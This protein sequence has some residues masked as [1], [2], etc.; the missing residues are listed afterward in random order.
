MDAL[1]DSTLVLYNKI[2]ENKDDTKLQEKI[3]KYKNN[4]SIQLTETTYMINIIRDSNK[5]IL[6]TITN[7]YNSIKSYLDKNI[8]SLKNIINDFDEITL[9]TNNDIIIDN[10]ESI[11]EQP[12]VKKTKKSTPKSKSQLTISEIFVDTSIKIEEDL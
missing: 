4:V 1:I 9:V 7:Q 2:S 8:M 3:N 12:Q 10:E 6:D 5:L 11:V